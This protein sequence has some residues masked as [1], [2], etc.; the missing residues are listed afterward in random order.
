MTSTATTADFDATTIDGEERS[1]GEY[2]GRVLLIVNVASRCGFTNQYA[3][4]EALWRRYRD[5]GLVVLG[6]PCDQFGRQELGS[7]AEIAEFCST[8]FD[9][10]F[11]MF[12]KVDV[13]GDGAH[14][15]F[16]W[17]RAQAPTWA[18]DRVRWNFTKFLV[19]RDGDTVTRHGSRT[20]PEELTA[21]I[22]ALLAG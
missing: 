2:A 11:P 6:F 14:P 17:L 21:D 19:S 13:N 15:L 7:E 9:V 20:A 1:L 16:A 3:G 8:T 4:L 22:E 10:T 5:Q 18:G 12:A